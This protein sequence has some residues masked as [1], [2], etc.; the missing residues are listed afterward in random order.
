MKFSLTLDTQVSYKA[1]G[2]NASWEWLETISPCIVALGDL[3]K[4]LN[5]ALGGDQAQNMH[6]QI[7]KMILKVS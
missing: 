5:N 2:S 7:L 6:P 4:T 3:Q 1:R